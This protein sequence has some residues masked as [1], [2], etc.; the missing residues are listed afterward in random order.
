MTTKYD[1][2]SVDDTGPSLTSDEIYDSEV[3][4]KFT[5][6]LEEQRIEKCFEEIKQ[7]LKKYECEFGW[8]EDDTVSISSK[9]TIRGTK[10]FS[11]YYLNDE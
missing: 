2:P 1:P 5:E 4:K 9:K 7:V 10:F 11:A 8:L 6:A 3:G